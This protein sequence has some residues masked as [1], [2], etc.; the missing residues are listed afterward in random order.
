MTSFKSSEEHVNS[1]VRP[2]LAD[3][4]SSPL[5]QYVQINVQE[6]PLRSFLV[7][8]FISSLRGSVP[9]KYHRTYLL[10]DQ[11]LEYLREPMGMGNKHVGYVFL[12][13]EKGKIRWAGCSWATAEEEEGLRKCCT[14]L[15]KR[16]ESERA[17]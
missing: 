7:S 4:D 9:E 10:S 15:V 5:F 16:L 14:V 13:D 8:L 3:M 17:H 1:F 6:N 12:V 2:T 11:S